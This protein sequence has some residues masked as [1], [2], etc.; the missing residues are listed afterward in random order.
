MLQRIYNQRIG[1][2]RKIPLMFARSLSRAH[3]TRHYSIHAGASS[4]WEVR[5]EEDQTLRRFDRYEDWH[6]V[7]RA[8]MLFER[9]VAELSE[10]G[11]RVDPN[12]SS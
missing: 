11:W 9:E 7:E 1:A 5:L 2:K 8:L 12:S 3:H 6:R 4:G 10:N